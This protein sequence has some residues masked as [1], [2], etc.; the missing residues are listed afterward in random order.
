MH[1]FGTAAGRRKILGD[2]PQRGEGQPSFLFGFAVCNL[3]RFFILVD[4]AG[5]HLDQPRVVGTAHGAH[6]KLLDQHHFITLRVI[7]QYTH[8]VVTDKDFAVDH[9]A[10]AAV[11]L[12]V[13]QL[14]TVKFI[15]A[16]V[17]IVAL[18]DFNRA[19]RRFCKVR[20]IP[21]SLCLGNSRHPNALAS[22]GAA[23]S[24]CRDRRR[25]SNSL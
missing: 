6:A 25:A 21:S 4:Q 12:L 1:K 15:E 16:L 14:H 22:V 17:G 8:R 7:G 2:R 10:H 5:D 3:L 13:A 23:P 19:R 20:H 18:H 9:A 24:G 11:E